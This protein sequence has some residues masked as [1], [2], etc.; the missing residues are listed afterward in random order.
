MSCKSLYDWVVVLILLNLTIEN[1]YGAEGRNDKVAS[2]E[3]DIELEKKLKILNKPP[4]KSI[5]TKLGDTYDC[6][7]IYKQPAFD[8]P[9]LR[10][11]KIQMKPN[12]IQGQQ[13][14]KPISNMV[15]NVVRPKIDGCPSETVPIRRTTKEELVNTKHLSN[16][17]KHRNFVLVL[18]SA[19]KVYYG[20]RAK[21]SIANPRVDPDKFS[22]SQIW[23]QNG[24][25]EE[26]NSIEFGWAVHPQLFGDYNARI[27]GL[28][29]AD[30]FKE[31]G[32]YNMLCPG[33]VQVH[34]EYSFG[35]QLVAGRYGGNQRAFDFSV[36]RDPESGNWWFING[37][38]NARIG[39]W[40]KEIFTHLS[41]NA[42]VIGYGGVAGADFGKLTPPMGYGYLPTINSAYT[43]CMTEMKVVDDRGRYLDFDTSKVHIDR[44]AKT[45]CY[46]LIFSRKYISLG[47]MMFFGGPGGDCL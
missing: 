26:I 31:T 22:T 28:W 18:P 38:D 39:Y 27:F 7:N 13:I 11:H 37:K 10:N 4:V 23:I 44:N 2:K 47:I 43:C 33:F 17:I 46:D 29:T 14:K 1:Y 19:E 3:E 42:S 20:G 30:G 21:I 36:H 16:W 45:S 15:F 34:P 9:L 6:I 41:E 5:Q 35:E 40:P 32:C 12:V 8:H 24:P 25:V